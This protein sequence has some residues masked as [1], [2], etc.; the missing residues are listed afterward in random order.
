M[1][2]ALVGIE[3]ALAAVPDTAS[4][5][6][7]LCG[8]KLRSHCYDEYSLARLKEMVVSRGSIVANTAAIKLV[9]RGNW[10]N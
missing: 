7:G 3:P 2:A 4:A 9:R 6:D 5:V 1:I 10:V 8:L